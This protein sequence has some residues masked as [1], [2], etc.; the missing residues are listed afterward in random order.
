[1]PRRVKVEGDLYHGRVPDGA[2]YV[3]RAAPGL[4]ASPFANPF[5]V[6]TYGR[7][8]AIRRYRDR[9]LGDPDLLDRARGELA[10]K[11]LAC[12]C[13]PDDQCHADVLIEVVNES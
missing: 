13:R 1:M 6:K 9:L 7:D 11:D 5:S 4:R 2:I 8:E 3:G 10:G 12:W